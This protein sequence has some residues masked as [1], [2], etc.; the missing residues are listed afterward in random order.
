M[1]SYKQDEQRLASL[2]KELNL[3]TAKITAGEITNELISKRNNLQ[4]S[5]KTIKD[6]LERKSQTRKEI[7]YDEPIQIFT[8]SSNISS[9]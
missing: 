1:M 2:Q 4:V 3:V 6:R 7:F 9:N 5:I 8:P